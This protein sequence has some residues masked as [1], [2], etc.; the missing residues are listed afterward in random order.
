LAY[1]LGV[2]I[3][4]IRIRTSQAVESYGKLRGQHAATMSTLERTAMTT[5]RIGMAFT[6]VGVAALAGFFLAAKASAELEKR[7]SF[8][9]AVT[10]ALPPQMDQVRQSIFSLAKEF[11]VMPNDI[12]DAYNELAKAGVTV[13]Q[14]V[15]EGWGKATLTLSRAA[16]VTASSAAEM[17]I[18]VQNSY[19]AAA[20][21]AQ[22][23]ADVLAGV[24]NA[25]SIDIAD[26]AVSMKYVG[27]TAHAMG[28]SLESTGAAL[29]VLAQNGIRGSTAGTSLR[30]ML[31]QLTGPT[32]TSHDEL[33]KLGIITKE[34]GNAFF[35]A[36]GKARQFAMISQILQ[37]ATK[38]LSVQQKVQA[39]N[40]I[41]GARAMAASVILSN[42]GARGLDLMAKAASRTTALEIARKRMDNLAG[43]TSKLKAALDVAFIQ[44]GAPAQG[45]LKGLVDW[46]TKLVTAFSNLSP[47]AQKIIVI[48]LLIVGTLFTLGGAFMLAVSFGLRLYQTF[49]LLKDAMVFFKTMQL[50]TAVITLVTAG[51]A[52][53]AAS[54]KGFAIALMEVEAQEVAAT[55]GIA[56]LVIALVNLIQDFI[57]GDRAINEFKKNMQKPMTDNFLVDYQKQIK[58]MTSVTEERLARQEHVWN[59]L[60]GILRGAEDWV[61]HPLRTWN[62]SMGNTQ[63]ELDN[64]SNEMQG[65][66]FGNLHDLTMLLGNVKHG[67]AT[68]ADEQNMMKTLVAMGMT[69][70]DLANTPLPQL[71]AR[72]KEFQMTADSSKSPAERAA[73]ALIDMGN[74]A[75]T[76]EQDVT[77]LK[78]ALDLLAGKALS[79]DDAAIAFRNN[80]A[81][82]DKKLKAAHGSLSMNSQ[83]SRDARSAF[84][85]TAES[86]ISLA[87][88]IKDSTDS[89]EKAKASLARSIA[90]LK[91]HAG[92]SDYAKGALE[93]MK[94]A[95]D[96][97]GD[98]APRQGDK[99]AAAAK[100]TADA[101]RSAAAEAEAAGSAVG[102]E[103]VHGLVAGMEAVRPQSDAQAAKVARSA[104]A[105]ARGPKGM[106]SGSPSKVGVEIGRTFPQ[107]LAKGMEKD[108]P[109]IEKSL[110]WLTNQI[111]QWKGPKHVDK[112][113]LFQSGK[114]IMDG[115]IRGIK[116]GSEG[117]KAQF[118]IITRRFD[119]YINRAKAMKDNRSVALFEHMKKQINGYE[120]HLLR[121]S[122]RR[123]ALIKRIEHQ[124]DRLRDKLKA[125]ADYA[126]QI[127]DQYNALGDVTNV[128]TATDASG[129]A[130]VT[131]D[132]IISGLQQRLAGIKDYHKNL[133]KLRKMGLSKREYFEL[134]QAGPEAGAPYVNALIQGGA[135]AIKQVNSL[136][137]Q[138]NTEATA[139]GKES[140]GAMYNAGISTVQGIIRGLKHRENH[141]YK[142]MRN[143]AK[144]MVRA[145]KKELG[146]HSPAKA[147]MYPGRMTTAGFAVGIMQE[148]QRVLKAANS[149]AKAALPPGRTINTRAAGISP[150]SLRASGNAAIAARGD[151]SVTQIIHSTDPKLASDESARKMRTLA[152]MGAFG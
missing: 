152:T 139:L 42:A 26:V 9:Q 72:V 1:S 25:S 83:A 39:L 51:F 41:F 91:N 58:E 140:S 146:I 61:G 135:G 57:H 53:A 7:L 97:L 35:T 17:V 31:I 15:A 52:A 70:D 76:A 12:A 85:Q 10:T 40:T 21:T 116:K 43:S 82:L 133:N 32:Q 27:A 145:L 92:S 106:D 54:A 8:L 123:D 16:E 119:Y 98:D 112:K 63:R 45:P 100:H 78:N 132:T 28:I 94:R 74:A 29:G 44:M 50:G 19:G 48:F 90:M 144:N 93:R 18:S 79:A 104:A 6:T 62:D 129:K 148:R 143:I 141:L 80:I 30:R 5:K 150:S 68:A 107:G 151:V 110:R 125:R 99:A 60:G 55:L 95:Y 138:I 47:S 36:S 75:N 113:L 105:A 81:D 56:L 126:K 49:I 127:K 87:T 147:L 2:A 115:L 131:S 22:H 65:H 111:P 84:N 34:G 33:E 66:L 86:A 102:I 38:K 23:T 73:Q 130:Y 121:V 89:S 88:G 37:A 114:A 67:F 77:D 71:I 109:L 11:G 101:M 108:Y 24:A 4:E 117:V 103:F 20:G 69:A 3:G 149:L 134:L 142:I 124:Q 64:L 46:I 118:D 136:Q 128:V 13:P 120:H 96:A 122:R 14:I 59:S 137:S